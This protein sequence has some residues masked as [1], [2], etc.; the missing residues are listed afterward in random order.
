MWSNPGEIGNGLDD[1]GNGFVDDI[2]GYDFVGANDEDPRD[3]NG[4]GSHVAG[5]IGA[6]GNNNNGIVGVNW[7][8]SLMAVRVLSAGGFGT[9]LDIAEGFDYAGDNG[10]RV[11]NASLGGPGVAQTLQDAIGAHPN[12]L[13]VVA[14]RW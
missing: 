14:S 6:V 13:Y 7:D 9:D 2:R 5:T 11:V 10:A 12:T 3:I 8:V 4:H 1:D